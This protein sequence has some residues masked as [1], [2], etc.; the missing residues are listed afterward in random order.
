MLCLTNLSVRADEWDDWGEEDSG[1]KIRR[2][3][4]SGWWNWQYNEFSSYDQ[5]RINFERTFAND[6]KLVAGANFNYYTEDNNKKWTVFPGENSYS[7]KAGS[8]DFKLGTILENIGS[9]DKFSFVDKINSR[10]FHNGLANDYNRDKKEIPALKASWYINRHFSLSGHYLPYFSAS[11]FPSIFS[12][13]AYAIH[14]S[15]ANEIL[16]NNAVYNAENDDSFDP[17]FH[18]EFSSTFRKLELRLHYLRLKERLPIISQDRPGVINGTYPIDETIAMNG[19][20]QLL[21]DLLVRFEFAFNREKTWSS[22]QDGR[23]GKKFVSDQYGFLLGTDKNLP[24][25]FYINVQ[26]MMSHVPD[27]KTQTPFQLG[28][29]EY[30]G[31]LQL[32]QNFRSDRLRIEFNSLANF[33]TGE[34]VITPKIFIQKSD[35]LTFVLGYQANGEGAESLGPVAQFSQNNTAFFET[36]VFF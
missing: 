11:E 4:I 24:Q 26:A 1:P 15:L 32:R 34:Y 14:K 2:P 31:S 7:F 5:G 29:T 36:R 17:Q 3:T 6:Q 10:R 20:I 21:D 27:L 25:N 22:Y 19:N 12:R 35:H 30:L 28:K 9:G 23:I 18:V 33:T 8:F 13:W 16:F